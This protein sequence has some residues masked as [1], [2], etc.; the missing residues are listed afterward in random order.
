VATF[1]AA[2][3]ND[4]TLLINPAQATV[5]VGVI[6]SGPSATLTFDG[7]AAYGGTTLSVYAFASDGALTGARLFRINVT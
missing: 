2:Y 6:G 7:F 4:P 3:Y 5:T 1:N